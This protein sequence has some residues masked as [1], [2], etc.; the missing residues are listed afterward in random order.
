MEFNP[1]LTY[2]LFQNL[3]VGTE[4]ATNNL[5]QYSRCSLQGSNRAPREF[6]SRASQLRQPAR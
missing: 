4:T 2:M 6:K 3:S 1:N 5:S